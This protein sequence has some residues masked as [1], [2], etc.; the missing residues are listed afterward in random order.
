MLESS[1]QNF[2][3]WLPLIIILALGAFLLL[4][5]LDHRPFWQDEAETACLAKN[6]LKYGVPRAYD[7]TNLVSQE[8]GHEFDQN[9]LWRW[10]PW[11][12]I[13][14]VAAAFKIGGLTNYAGRFPF[15]L[16]GIACIFLVY[17]LVNHNF[18]DQAWAC[19]AALLL[20]TSVV[21]LLFARQCR[22][23]SLGTLL[24]L[25]N[26]YAFRRDW[27]NRTIPALLLGLSATLMFYT[28]YLLFFSYFIPFILAAFLLYYSDIR[29]LRALLIIFAVVVTIIPGLLLFRIQQ[30]SMMV[31][32]WSFIPKN[33]IDYFADLF[34][35]LIPLPIALF[36][37]Y[38]W[39][40]SLWHRANL[41]LDP[42]EKFILFLSLIITGNIIVLSPAPQ[43]EV[44]YLIHLSP[45]CAIILGWVIC[46]AWHY[47]KFSGVLLGLLLLGTNWLY[48]LPVEWLG[49]INRP[50]HND[51]HMLSYPNFPLKLY[52][53]ELTSTYPDV[54]Q[55]LIRFFQ[56][57][58]RPGDVILT[59]YGDLPLQFY[60]SCKV[61]GGLQEHTPLTRPPRWL[62]PRWYVRRNRQ[63]DLN[64]SEKAIRQLLAQTGAYQTIP[65][66]YED[67]IFGN[68]PDPY[69]HRF[70][71]P[72]E[73]LSHLVIYE[74]KS[75]AQPAP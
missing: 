43:D 73:P 29:F 74:K 1:R 72:I 9:F 33:S 44:R 39:G 53:N 2:P 27:Q 51:P 45:L 65:L 35:F 6:V 17:Q 46:R 41:F 50:L 56:T 60:T 26:L 62:V 3:A 47:H 23:Y 49:I 42:S 66:P 8:Q 15:A 59:T 48:V 67:E 28:N 31:N 36:L 7:G 71:P 30:Q 21:F 63:Y 75:T 13:Y 54:N 57:H 68:R 10:S 18:G 40:R 52:L 11:L 69:F 19:L 22:Y 14:V 70:I 16:M 12:Q 38:R 58:A 20:T 64:D 37:L 5:H 55:E 25:V 4:F 61:L 24:V 34:Q 32:L